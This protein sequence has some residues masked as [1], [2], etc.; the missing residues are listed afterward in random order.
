[1][2]RKFWWGNRTRPTKRELWERGK[3]QGTQKEHCEEAKRKRDEIE[4]DQ[5]KGDTERTQSRIE[6]ESQRKQK[7][8][9]KGVFVSYH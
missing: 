9:Q 8:K 2:E 7:V 4:P 1:M 5:W 3:E 6:K